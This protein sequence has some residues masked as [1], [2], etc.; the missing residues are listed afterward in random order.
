MQVF[1]CKSP[2]YLPLNHS[3]FFKGNPRYY[4]LMYSSRV[5]YPYT[6]ISYI[7][8]SLL[9]PLP[10]IHTFSLVCSF[11]F[12]TRLVACSAI[13]LHVAFSLNILE[14]GLTSLV[15][16]ELHYTTIKYSILRCIIINLTY[17]L[18]S[19]YFQHFL[20]KAMLL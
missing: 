16:I 13:V 20:F 8:L 2:S 15:C 10:L 19:A 3:I 6:S 1:K 9:F 5:F 4:F 18:L 11:F 7:S 14:A 12:L 17:S